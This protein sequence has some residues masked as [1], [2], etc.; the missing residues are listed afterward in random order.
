MNIIWNNGIGIRKIRLLVFQP[1]F[2]SF[3]N[4]EPQAATSFPEQKVIF[5]INCFSM[6]PFFILYWNALRIENKK[7][8]RADAKRIKWKR[9]NVNTSSVDGIFIAFAVIHKVHSNSFNR[10]RLIDP[11]YLFFF[12]LHYFCAVSFF[13]AIDSPSAYVVFIVVIGRG[14]P[15]APTLFN[16]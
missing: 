16:R 6:L 5:K 10:G 7:N 13:N 1:S 11:F 8:R 15:V 4:K 3:R 14:W 2:F 12:F 9:R